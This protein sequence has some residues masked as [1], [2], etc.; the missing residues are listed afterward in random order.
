MTGE[1][2][3]LRSA[4]VEELKRLDDA[5]L[6]LQRSKDKAVQ[7]IRCEFNDRLEPLLDERRKMLAG[8][9]DAENRSTV[10]SAVDDFWSLALQNHPEV[11][12]F[13][14]EWDLPVL[15]YLRDISSHNLD[16]L[17]ARKGFQLRFY[18]C[19][20]PYFSNDALVKTYH[21]QEGS[22]Y[23]SDLRARLIEVCKINWKAGKNVTIEKV[24]AERGKKQRSAKQAHEDRPSLFRNFFR[25]IKESS[26]LPRDMD[27]Q[28]LAMELGA[29]D[30]ADEKDL[31]AALMNADYVCGSAIRDQ[32][33]PHAVR[34]YT[35]E[36]APD[37]SE[38]DSDC[39]S[40]IGD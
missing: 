21:M 38:C 40:S 34:W 28:E 26:P 2:R 10:A 15:R 7:K 33:I 36:A 27:L 32:V 11:A 16:P 22:P 13:I 14:E 3:G 37:D 18:F 1:A 35:G 24:K 39:D 4:V 5:Y 8:G 17:D 9:N 31:V 29:E 30:D 23:T 12:E 6:E 25:T 20:N 19:D